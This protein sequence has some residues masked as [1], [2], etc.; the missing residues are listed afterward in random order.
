MAKKRIVRLVNITGNAQ[1]PGFKRSILL[2]ESD[3]KTI[4][5]DGKSI[6]RYETDNIVIVKQKI[7]KEK[8]FFLVSINNI[9]LLKT[10]QLIIFLMQII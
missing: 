3:A 8:I 2:S 4:N 7:I 10:I 1:I 6:A 5:S 9:S